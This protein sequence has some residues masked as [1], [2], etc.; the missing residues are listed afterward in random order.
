MISSSFLFV[1]STGSISSFSVSGISLL[2]SVVC[3]VNCLYSSFLTDISLAYS[4]LLTETVS[5]TTLSMI[6]SS[7]LFV[8][9]TG[10]ISSFSVLSV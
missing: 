6:S 4:T 1:I 7:F 3:S 2:I 10:C 5:K 9:S 8:I